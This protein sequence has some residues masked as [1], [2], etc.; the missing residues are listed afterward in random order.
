[1]F[2]PHG[3][4]A[5]EFAIE[6][7]LLMPGTVLKWNGASFPLVVLDGG[8]R[9][10]V[11]V[12]ATQLAN[13]GVA[14]IRLETPGGGLSPDILFV[15]ITPPVCTPGLGTGGTISVIKAV[16]NGQEEIAT[17]TLSRLQRMG[18]WTLN[19]MGDDNVT[20]QVFTFPAAYI[21]QDDQPFVEVRSGVEQFANTQTKL[22]WRLGTVWSNSATDNAELRDCEGNLIAQWDDPG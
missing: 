11:T 20:D 13:P 17:I 19:S 21:Y 16:P 15:G 3:S 8:S 14:A 12:A 9:A 2:V 22:W 5:T 7:G 1:V 18:G 6:G 10:I 4:G